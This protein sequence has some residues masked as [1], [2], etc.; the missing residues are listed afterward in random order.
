MDTT[1]MIQALEN[2]GCN[3]QKVP[4]DNRTL[5]VDGYFHPESKGLPEWL[6]HCEGWYLSTCGCGRAFVTKVE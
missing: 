3:V 2:A 1:M 6:W 5:H 4:G